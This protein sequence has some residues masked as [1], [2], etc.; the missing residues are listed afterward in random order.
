VFNEEHDGEQKIS[1]TARKYREKRS[2]NR[3]M[4]VFAPVPGV[5]VHGNPLLLGV[6]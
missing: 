2:L 6:F 5:S 4:I 1:Q 3:N